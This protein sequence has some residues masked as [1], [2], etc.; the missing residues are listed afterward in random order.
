MAAELIRTE[1]EKSPWGDQIVN[2]YKCSGCGEEVTLNRKIPGMDTYCGKCSK[3]KMRK[4]FEDKEASLMN[5]GANKVLKKYIPRVRELVG[6]VED[7]RA[8]EFINGI[9]RDMEADAG[10]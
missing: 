1:R 7:K 3:K 2:I 10:R 5:E 6:I 8:A 4:R 9:I